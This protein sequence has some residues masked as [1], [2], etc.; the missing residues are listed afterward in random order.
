SDNG[1]ITFYG[2][3][4]SGVNPPGVLAG[5]FVPADL[6]ATDITG[7]I[8]WNKPQQI[9]G[10]R[11]T[12]KGGVDTILTANGSVYAGVIPPGLVGAGTVT[13]S[14]GGFLAPEVDAVTLAAGLPAPAGSLKA[15]AGVKADLG[16]FRARVIVPGISKPV[17]GGGIY[18]PKS[19]S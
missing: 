18:L 16:T 1:T 8:A 10:G 17:T 9:P 14:G 4:S 2:K 15:W 12:Q 6:A 3:E 11:G 5:Q 7:E 13:I 19:N